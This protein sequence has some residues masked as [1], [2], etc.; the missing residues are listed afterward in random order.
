MGNTK[1]QGPPNPQKHIMLEVIACCTP[2]VFMMSYYFGAG[3]FKNIFFS[4]FFCC[5]LESLFQK[6]FKI[7]KDFSAALTGILLA[8]SIP[9]GFPVFYLLIGCI[10]AIIIAKQLY[11][12]LGHNIFNPALVGYMVLLL[13]FPQSATWLLDPTWQGVSTEIVDSISQ[14]TPLDHLIRQLYSSDLMSLQTNLDIWRNINLSWLLGGL[15]LVIR[16]KII[17]PL[18]L[19]YLLGVLFFSFFTSM[20]ISHL[21]LG[22]TQISA[23]FIITD[24]VTAATTPKG[25]WIYGFFAGLF[26]VFMRVYSSYPE[27]AAFAIL[28]MNMMAPFINHVTIQKP[29]GK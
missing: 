13:S 11:G 19:S 10:F 17:L 4:V 5:L 26:T 29:F 21:L 20:G 15:L 24:P 3:V 7:L 6:S 18:M 28:L 14:A 16:K 23:F 27:G 22:A 9:P 25:Q 2:G 12:G 8:V 1:K